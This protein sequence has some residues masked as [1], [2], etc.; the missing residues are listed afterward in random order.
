MSG[1]SSS[2]SQTEVSVGEWVNGRI[3]K[4]LR[5]RSRPCKTLYYRLVRQPNTVVVEGQGRDLGASR[6]D[7]MT[8]T[9]LSGSRESERS[10]V[11]G[12]N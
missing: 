2:S 12:P 4:L 6:K 1:S 8:E 11:D 9:L 5:S 7:T 10:L 3:S